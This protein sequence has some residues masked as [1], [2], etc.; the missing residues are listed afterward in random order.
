MK[1]TFLS[2]GAGVQTTALEI[3]IYQG[4]VQTDEII[5]SDTG[6]EKPETYA[7]IKK[8]LKPLADEIGVPFATVHLSCEIEV[9]DENNQ[10]TGEK[11]QANSLRDII[12]ARR[13]VPSLMHRWCTEKSKITPIKLYIRDLQKKGIYGRP[14]K[15]LIGIS[16][17]EKHRMH[18]PHHGEYSN[19]FPLVEMGISRKDCEQIIRDFGWPLPVKSGCYLCPFQGGKEWDKLFY[20]HND[21]F[22]DAMELE[23]RDIKYPTYR[24]YQRETLERFAEKRKLGRHNLSIFDDY[25]GEVCSGACM[26]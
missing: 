17:D 14:S 16:T 4:R 7:Y 12:E 9:V 10:K 18:Q 5:F 22:N 25:E 8:Y 11:I 6:L 2:M 21:L 19:E 3:L 15:G 26:L 24:L 23:K 20:E 13:R 1:T